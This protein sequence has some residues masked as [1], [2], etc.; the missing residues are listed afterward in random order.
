MINKIQLNSAQVNLA[1]TWLKPNYTPYA[2]DP[3]K[4]TLWYWQ[5]WN[6]QPVKNAIKLSADQIHQ[7]DQLR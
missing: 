1:K 2:Y 5:S 3:T 7:L 4:G 6:G